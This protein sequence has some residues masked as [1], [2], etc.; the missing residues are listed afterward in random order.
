MKIGSFLL[1]TPIEK[2][3]FLSVSILSPIEKMQ[4][5]TFISEIKMKP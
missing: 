2:G 5:I 4:F 1:S 3:I